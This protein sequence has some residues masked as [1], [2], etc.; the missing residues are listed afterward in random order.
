MKHDNNSGAAIVCGNRAAMTAC[1]L[2]AGLCAIA[3]AADRRHRSRA[4]VS[5]EH[6]DGHQL[7]VRI[8]EPGVPSPAGGDGLGPLFNDTSCLGC[9]HQGGTGG[10]G[11]NERN[12]VLLSA[13]AAA[14]NSGLGDSVFKGELEDLH[15]GFRNHESVVVHR[16][17]TDLALES[18]L[19]IMG[20][21]SAVQTRDDM[22]PVQTSQRNT[23]ALFG[24]GLIDA[25]PDKILLDAEKRQFA[26]Y[27]EVKGKASHLPDGRLGRFG[28]KGQTASL[29][30]FVLTACANELGLEVVGHHQV[31]LAAAKDF[32][33]AKLKLDLG[34]DQTDLLVGFVA[35]LPPPFLA[36]VSN[37]TLPP[38]G[39]NA[40]QRIGCAT[41]HAPRLGQ[42]RGLYSDLLLHDLGD[43][44]RASG[45][46]GMSTFSSRIVDRVSESDRARSPG[47][48]SANEWRT[49]P[50]WGVADSAPY[51]HDGRASNL[52]E[53]IRLHGGEAAATAERYDKLA[54]DER[55][56]LLAFLQS[57]TVGPRPREH[58]AS[59][60]KHH[61]AKP[62][63]R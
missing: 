20:R 40:F 37:F 45:G 2:V 50:L 35:S 53:A 63:K 17:A 25:I 62:K 24:A 47:G 19:K 12:V 8:W 1:L 54:S 22:I 42:V 44:I 9:H 31:S 28:W 33:P 30:D 58:A 36:N 55:R 52:D 14:S 16:H 15:P 61:K 34:T 32:D 6:F 49:P 29:R 48:V 5:R 7:F 57:L 38:W 4:T 18:R 11:G 59:E 41:C 13:F 27:P 23:P 10:G 3:S 26:N 43:R 46:Y 39:Y 21:T 51:L 56:A 60:A